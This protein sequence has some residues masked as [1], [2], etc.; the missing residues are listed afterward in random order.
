MS[1]N[2]IGNSIQSVSDIRVA[3]L[4][5][6]EFTNDQRIYRE[7]FSIAEAGYDLTLFAVYKQSLPKEET[8]NGI[9]VKRLFDKKIHDFKTSIS[10]LKELAALI[11]SY[12]PHIL[13]CHD[14]Q[15]LHLGVLIKKKLPEVVL[16]YDSHE[17][18]HEWPLHYS[19]W[20]PIV[21]IKS[22]LVR[23]FEIIREWYDKKYI[24]HIITV[25]QSLADDLQKYLKA[26][27]P[28]TVVRNFVLYEEITER[29]DYVRKKFNIPKDHKVVVLF[30]FLIYKKNRNIEQAISDLGNQKNIALVIFCKDGGHKEYF[31]QLVAESNLTNI[32]FHDIIDSSKIVNTLASCDVGIIPTWNKKYLSYWLGLENK[33]FHYV[34]S[35]LPILSAAQPEHKNIISLYKI[36]A[37]INGDRK[38]AFLDGFNLILNNY[39]Y[40]KE[41][42][43]K[44]KHKL[45]WDTEK[46]HLIS[47]YHK[48]SLQHF[49]D[50]KPLTGIQ[51]R[52]PEP[53]HKHNN[54]R[55]CVRCVFNNFADPDIYFN[56]DGLCNHCVL[57]DKINYDNLVTD[58]ER[59]K[60]FNNLIEKIKSEGK[61]KKYDC[62]IG[63]SGGVDSSY[64][65]YLTV[66]AGL[67]PLAVHLDNG[68]N[69]EL[70]VKNIENI[71]T[72]LGI[73][74]YTHVIKWDEFRDLQLSYLK[75]SVVD[76]EAPSDH[77][78][79][80]ALF[81][82]AAKHGIKYILSGE[83]QVTEG[84]LPESWNYLKSDT[85]N[86]KAIHNRFGTIPLKTFPRLGFFKT[87]LYNKV[88][89]I[90][91]IKL[92]DHVNYIKKE[93]KKILADELGWRDYGGKHYESIIT[94][95]YQS[96]IL[97]NKFHIDKRYSHY[98]TLICSGQMTKEEAYELLAQPIIDENLLREDKIFIIKKF[99]L[100]EQQFLDIMNATPKSHTDYPNIIDV[101][102]KYKPLV[103]VVKRALNLPSESPYQ[104]KRRKSVVVLLDQF[105]YFNS[106]ITDLF[107]GLANY[108]SITAIGLYDRK[109]DY[110]KT[111]E[112]LL[113]KKLPLNYPGTDHTSRNIKRI[114]DIIARYGFEAIHCVNKKTL[115][116]ALEIKKLNPSVR[117]IYQPLLIQTSNQHEQLSN[118][119]SKKLNRID[120]LITYNKIVSANNLRNVLSTPIAPVTDVKQASNLLFDFYKILFA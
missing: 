35:E 7:A 116:I 80:A 46:Y 61:G 69:T 6:N 25:N 40:Y 96:Y 18:F 113:F 107:E 36:G 28:V 51:F 20:S 17:L 8:I 68:W 34:M 84:M 56:E 110:G 94:R 33:L 43:I 114:S 72:K 64:V 77:A 47:L 55:E 79:F 23:K 92:L 63:L 106:L 95:F 93:A 78:I 71:V 111:S 91:T 13:H 24:D 11:A 119:D 89:R 118:L 3:M 75:A 29:N 31:K 58:N 99:G 14:W 90:K 74:L 81:N 97:P 26:K 103:R 19:S 108:Y 86:I 88:Y 117:I 27:S 10:Y 66:K 85:I 76:L 1:D 52:L 44:S 67:R 62:I 12:K 98:S 70:A 65:A 38:G 83:S 49:T 57:Y 112:G 104:I 102:R 48:I 59:N 30:S 9:K 45:S 87:I 82:E 60:R 21:M 53:I 22:Q 54:Y 32:F 2:I 50:F 5:D 37:C 100:T 41:N 15:M 115:I 109:L 73:D 101:A 16:I 39:S 105:E 42:I 120:Y 4:C